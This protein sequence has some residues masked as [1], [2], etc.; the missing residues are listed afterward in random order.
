MKLCHLVESPHPQES[1]QAAQAYISYA[2]AGDTLTDTVFTVRPDYIVIRQYYDDEE[3]DKYVVY[4]VDVSPQVWQQLN[5]IALSHTHS[6][7]N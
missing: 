1:I 4:K 7:G 6:Q 5:A 3:D 2:T